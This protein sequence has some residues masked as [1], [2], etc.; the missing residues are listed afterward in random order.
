MARNT[1]RSSGP[2]RSVAFKPVS[3]FSVT[4]RPPHLSLSD[5]RKEADRLLLTSKSTSTR[6]GYTSAFKHWETFVKVYSLPFKPT[7]SSLVLF[8]AFLS[9]RLTRPEKI[10]SAVAYF[11]KSSMPNWDSIRS[12]PSVVDALAGARISNPVET[13]RTPPLL[14][15]HLRSIVSSAISSGSH[16]DLLFAFMATVGF[17][18]L[19]RLG[20]MTL[21]D[22]AQDRDP[23]KWVRRSSASLSPDR[24]F[25]FTLPY[26]KA[27]KLFRGSS[28]VLLA[29]NSTPDFNFIKV[30]EA[31]LL[32]RDSLFDDSAP[33][34]FLTR[35]GQIPTR[36]WFV[37]RLRVHA[38]N[39]SGHG[40]RAGGCTHYA[41]LGVPQ[42]VIQR[43][44]RWSSS[45][46]EQYIR[47]HPAV[48]AKFQRIALR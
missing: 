16:N 28:V 43:L 13:R 10:L 11:F 8:V 5:L 7:T 46:F 25:D 30:C 39:V 27:D 29:E 19:L 42:H 14:P 17:G 45:A 12:H 21:P 20:E 6:R 26:H 4:S 34:L 33:W 18:A 3:P 22:N 23:R 36:R 9:R 35:S 41:S 37:D 47:D 1:D 38:P 40:L 2:A 31:Y 24:Q 48:A 32:S 44:G 15:S